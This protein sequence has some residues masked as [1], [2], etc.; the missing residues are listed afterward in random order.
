MSSFSRILAPAL[1][2]LGF[3]VACFTLPLMLL[4]AAADHPLAFGVFVAGYSVA[5][6]LVIV[7]EWI[8]E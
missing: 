3:T 6:V 8:A 4:A 5:T 2:C 7:A 1:W